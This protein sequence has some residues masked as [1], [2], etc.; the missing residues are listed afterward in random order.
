[1]KAPFFLLPVILFILSCN[2]P[3]GHSTGIDPA[4]L[5]DSAIY[6]ID[7]VRLATGGGNEKAAAKK[8]A[9]ALDIYLNV[10]DA[11]KSIPIF[12]NAIRMNPSPRAYYELGC[13]LLDDGR[14]DES[15]RALHIAEQLGYSPR[16]NVMFRLSAAYAD[17]GNGGERP[18]NWRT[19]D[20][21]SLHYMEV[22]IQ[23]GF[24]HPEQFRNGA[25]FKRMNND[26][27]FNTVYTAALSG[28]S[29]SGNPE[30]MLWKTFTTEFPPVELPL[31]INTVWIQGHKLENSISYDYEKFIPEMRNAKFS[32]EVE[33]DY[34][35][36]A[37]VKKDPAYTAL[38]Y[39][40]KNN[41]LTDANQNSPTFFFLVTY[42]GDG[43]IIDKL[44]VAGQK[45]FTATWK[46][47]S[48][49]PNYAFVVKD[50]K[51][52]FKY[53]PETVG[54]DS[55]YVVKSEPLAITSYRIAANGKFEK[56]DA[57]LAMR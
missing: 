54:Y 14:Y 51:N 15:I 44:P 30:K 39:A 40:G 7:S 27:S 16:P 47:F 11:A 23:M 9:Q 10:K 22:A 52:V 43:K 5:S 6:D 46:V 53:D 42:D 26:Y 19:T 37:L 21:L 18:D 57:P 38:L 3:F 41:F 31:T 36:C 13:A 49:Q 56:T 12:K 25:F 28:G 4:T 32:R 24:G 55:N 20:S 17:H 29:A 50:F 35:Y 2:H 1:M 45:N 48:M 8:L 34:Y 33:N